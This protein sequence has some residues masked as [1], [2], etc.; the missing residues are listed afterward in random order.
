MHPNAQYSTIYNS[1]DTEAT[2]MSIDRGGKEDA[3]GT[4]TQWNTTQP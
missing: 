2:Y 3:L 1:H 4:Y